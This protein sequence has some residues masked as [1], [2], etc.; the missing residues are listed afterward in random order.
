MEVPVFF[1]WHKQVAQLVASLSCTAALLEDDR[2][3]TRQCPKAMQVITRK[4]QTLNRSASVMTQ[5]LKAVP[6]GWPVALL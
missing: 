5:G 1:P 3:Q 2:K 4:E 6:P